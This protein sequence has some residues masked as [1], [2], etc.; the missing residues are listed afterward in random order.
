MVGC[1][2]LGQP[3]TWEQQTLW[4]R[5]DIGC[6]YTPEMVGLCQK[7]LELRRQGILKF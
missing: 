4:S 6:R 1:A 3:G 7:A 5:G 2:R